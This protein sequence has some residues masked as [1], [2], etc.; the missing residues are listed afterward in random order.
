MKKFLALS[1]ATAMVAMTANAQ[2]ATM[3]Q[4]Q[5]FAM[6]EGVQL[7]KATTV[8]GYTPVAKAATAR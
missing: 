5:K 8:I 2:L 3:S 7:E 1:F 4:V 6:P